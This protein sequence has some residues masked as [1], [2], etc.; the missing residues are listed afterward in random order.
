MGSGSLTVPEAH[1][2]PASL[3]YE[4]ERYVLAPALT[5]QDLEVTP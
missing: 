1:L 3:Y 5:L 4:F 2:D